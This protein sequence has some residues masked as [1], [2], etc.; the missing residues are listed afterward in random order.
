MS[1]RR[2]VSLFNQEFLSGGADDESGDEQPNGPQDVDGPAEAPEI[3]G[4]AQR[5]SDISDDNSSDGGPLTNG[6]LEPDPLIDVPAVY[7]YQHSPEELENHEQRAIIDS[8]RSHV[9]GNGIHVNHDQEGP[10][11]D[12]EVYTNG[13]GIHTNGTGSF[14]SNRSRQREPYER[15]SCLPRPT[16]SS[17]PNSQ[18]RRPLTLPPPILNPSPQRPHQL[19]S[20]NF[21][22]PDMTPPESASRIPRPTGSVRNNAPESSPTTYR[23][24]SNVTSLPPYSPGDIMRGPW[25]YQETDVALPGTI[26]APLINHPDDKSKEI[27][28]E[29]QEEPQQ[30]LNLERRLDEGLLPFNPPENTVGPT[31]WMGA[32]R[33]TLHSRASI[34]R[35]L[36]RL[37]TNFAQPFSN[38][39]DPS[40]PETSSAVPENTP[41]VASLI[42]DLESQIGNLR[43]QLS[44][45]QE[46]IA[47]EAASVLSPTA[48]VDRLHEYL[49]PKVAAGPSK[50]VSPVKISASIR[51][52]K[53][54]VILDATNSSI[55]RQ[56]AV[57]KQYHTTQTPR[58]VLKRISDCLTAE[59]K[60]TRMRQQVFYLSG[61]G[62]GEEFGLNKSLHT[63]ILDAYTYLSD[64]WVIG[65][66]IILFGFS[67]GAFAVRAIAALITEIGL[68]NKAGMSHFETLYDT[69]FDP[70]YGKCRGT[71]EYERWRTQCTILA[72]ELGQKDGVTVTKV[73]VKFLGCLETI[74][75]SN[76]E[77]K[78]SDGCQDSK[79]LWERGAFDF[80]HLLLH[81]SIEN[82]FHALALDEERA[83]HAPL[84]MFRPIKSIKPLTQ[85]WFTGSHVNIG[86]GQLTTELAKNVAS[87]TPDQNELSDIIFLFLITECHRFLSFSKKH[88]SRCVSDYI[89]RQSRADVVK[90]I[91]FKYHWVS[92][93][94]DKNGS[95]G[96]GKSLFTRIR[97]AT[98]H[99]KKH[100]RTP[101]RYRPHWFHWDAWGRYKSCEAIH[102]SSQ[103]R[104]KHYPD[105][106]PK[107]LVDYRC[108]KTFERFGIIPEP[109]GVV[110]GETSTLKYDAPKVREEKFYYAGEDRKNKLLYPRN[111]DLPI[112][113]LSAFEILFAG[114]D[115]LIFGFG[116]A[117][118]DIYRESP[119]VF[120]YTLKELTGMR[121]DWIFRVEAQP[122]RLGS[123]KSMSDR[124][125]ALRH[126]Q[127]IPASLKYQYR[128]V[129][130]RADP[131][132]KRNIPPLPARPPPLP[133]RSQA[134]S[135]PNL[136]TS[137]AGSSTTEIHGPFSFEKEGSEQLED[138]SGGGKGKGRHSSN[139]RYEDDEDEY[140]GFEIEQGPSGYDGTD[141]RDSEQEQEQKPEP[142][143]EQGAGPADQEEL[144]PEPGPSNKEKKS[145]RRSIRKFFSFASLRGKKKNGDSGG[146]ASG[147]GRV[148]QAHGHLDG[149]SEMSREEAEALRQLEEA[150]EHQE[151]LQNTDRSQWV[152]PDI[153]EPEW[154]KQLRK[155]GEVQPCK[156]KGKHPY[157]GHRHQKK[158]REAR[159]E[160]FAIG[161]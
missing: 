124:A 142:E 35:H 38:Y 71:D 104:T 112:V 68:L 17:S 136:K 100:I 27:R 48:R 81:E 11:N 131:G 155:G 70:R 158:R 94:I 58:T 82:A 110:P 56:M 4:L 5:D 140:R 21:T 108:T 99:R 134:R 90:D 65:D 75:W 28:E 147:G 87:S 133:P 57:G 113:K 161:L 152:L 130:N 106:V 95:D 96:S 79:K 73:A 85:V 36:P 137:T 9:N 83:S 10:E 144:G 132:N 109:A 64:N 24:V 141:D 3:S 40:I 30:T 1:V 59:H 26:R 107:A 153:D 129:N 7:V 69:Y 135:T 111:I 126:A 160:T 122:S 47:K 116:I 89:G 31:P 86:G 97:N 53:I 72:S 119:P 156:H 127:S 143:P 23:S 139:L 154:M 105:Y 123:P 50:K 120:K 29:S 41:T 33:S 102:V 34:T 92:S 145:I 20:P 13:T 146:L 15:P 2:I 84:L 8:P 25:S 54:V 44:R 46:E 114:G 32:D 55:V 22:R 117:F 19:Q 103:Y 77:D 91:Q 115:A 63:T 125:I 150:R 159:S 39:S 80:R 43:Q 67:R 148:G 45:S 66:E 42:R 118:K 12:T 62:S 101:Q 14:E 149:N 16:P 37:V 93:N 151:W 157:Q 78:P 74:G 121:E 6:H 128:I 98:G 18:R 61:Y 88:V 49:E 51:A 60:D 76:Y 52:K 138:E